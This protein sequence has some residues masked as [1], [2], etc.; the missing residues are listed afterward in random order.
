MFTWLEWFDFPLSSEVFVVARRALIALC[1]EICHHTG[2]Y[3][4]PLYDDDHHE[5]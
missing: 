1:R 5:H 4:Q 2:D 3:R